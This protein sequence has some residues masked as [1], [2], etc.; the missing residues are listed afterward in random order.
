LIQFVVPD[1]YGNPTTLNYWGVWN[2]AELVGYIGLAQFI[3]AITAIINLI[4]KN[5]YVLFFVCVV[6]FSLIFSL[7]TPLAVFPFTL[8]IPLL[9]TAQPTRLLSLIDLSLA[10]L[11]AF[12]FNLLI[13]KKQTKSI[14]SFIFLS[15]I[16][17]ALWLFVYELLFKSINIDKVNLLV[18]KRNLIFPTAIFLSVSFAVV[19]LNYIKRSLIRNI[20]ILG[21]ITIALIY[22]VSFTNLFPFLRKI[23]FSQIPKQ[24]LFCKIICNMR[25]L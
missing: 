4:R 25:D 21:I 11:S 14:I 8:N 9:S 17:L 18:A 3:F 22:F 16:L 7:P 15:L 19:L 6:I 24:F 2:Y 1:F 5:Y 23:I 10:I 12:G 20:V 13:E